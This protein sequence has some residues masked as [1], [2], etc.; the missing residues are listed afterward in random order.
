MPPRVRNGDI[1]VLTTV[2]DLPSS[3]IQAGPSRQPHLKQW[4]RPRPLRTAPAQTATSWTSPS[5]PSSHQTPTA[6]RRPSRK[7]EKKWY[8]INCVAGVEFDLP[9]GLYSMVYLNKNQNKRV[10][11]L[12]KI[13][14]C[15]NLVNIDYTPSTL[16]TTCHVKSR[17]VQ[18]R[19]ITLSDV[20]FTL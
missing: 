8:L 19:Q 3:T 9:L 1:I 10:V 4:H 20:L 11:A 18:H 2:N 13:V 12:D 14:H 16:P 7:D 15:H 5:D 17:G 6:R